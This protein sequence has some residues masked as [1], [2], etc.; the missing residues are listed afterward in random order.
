MYHMVLILTLEVL[1][2]EDE[3]WPKKI[4][5]NYVWIQVLHTDL[6]LNQDKSI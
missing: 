2:G 1:G 5:N 6:V 3:L 4:Y